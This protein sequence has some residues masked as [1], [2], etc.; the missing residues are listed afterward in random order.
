VVVRAQLANHRTVE[1]EGLPRNRWPEVASEFRLFFPE[2]G[3]RM[4]LDLR[5][6]MLN[7]R[8]SPPRGLAFPDPRKAGVDR[9]IQIDEACEGEG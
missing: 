6:M 2:N 5:E 1:V 7:R 8:G 4:E 9:V 3:T